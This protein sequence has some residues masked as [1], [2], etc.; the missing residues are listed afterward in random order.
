[1][2]KD[3][4]YRQLCRLSTLRAGWVRVEESDGCAGVDGITIS[5]FAAGLEEELLRLSSELSKET[6]KPLPLLR[7]SVPKAHGGERVLSVPTVRDRVVENGLSSIIGPIF[8]REFEACSFAYRTGHSVKQALQQIEFLHEAGYTW[9]VDADITSYFDNV[10][11]ALLLARVAGLV[12]SARIVN[13]VR[14]A[15][16]ARVYDGHKI[17]LLERGLPQGAPISPLL[18]NLYLDSFDDRMLA[19]G[20][21]L[22]RFADDFVV[23]CKSE[24]KAQHALKLTRQLL[25][26]LH[27]TLNEEKTRIT[28]FAGGFDYL[29][30]TFIGNL[31]FVSRRFRAREENHVLMPPPLPVLRAIPMRREPFSPV[32]RDA[33][34]QA[35][36][37]VAGDEVPSFFQRPRG[38]AADLQTFKPG[39]SPPSS[40]VSKD[41]ST[42]AAAAE[43]QLPE[44]ESAETASVLA[45][46]EGLEGGPSQQ[47]PPDS[48]RLPPP[49]LLTLRTLYIHEH[50]ALIRCEDEHLRV[51]KDDVELLSLPAFKIDQIVLFGNS[52]ITTSA[53]KFCLR[54]GIPI[55]ILSGQ[56]QFFGTVESTGNQ[57]V[58]LQQIQFQRLADENFVL[59]TARQIV[60]GKISNSRT[61][62]QRRHR[63][64]PNDRLAQSIN[65]LLSLAS[66]LR[67]AGT[68]D[69]IRGHEGAAAASYFLAFA[70][71]TPASFKFSK[72]T[73]QPPL[74]PVNA[75]LSFGYTLLFY[76]IYAIVRLRGLS[77]YVGSLHALRQGHPA[78][79]SDLIEELRAPIID[80]L[81][82][83]LI[84]KM[85]FT[86]A[87]FYFGG[88]EETPAGCFLTDQARRTF[89]A[90]F[91]RR[92]NTL[93]LHPL[94]KVRTTWR[95][96]MDLQVTSF[97]RA[98]RGETEMYVPL[99]IR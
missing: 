30:A 53:M 14:D 41:A 28:S 9:V 39:D 89:V 99:E 27:L 77:P 15:V 6:Y 26:S 94:A 48:R 71:C 34:L 91:E 63:E 18:A 40:A 86:P 70:T 43:T 79:C 62:L 47:S 93:V 12:P 76:N 80:S 25:A 95:G 66:A 97:I 24:P 32:M 29:G 90:Q 67:N 36:N 72:R 84:N 59:K 3:H 55:I 17:F 31:A 10:D 61:L 38:R 44:A 50:G 88:S 92:M 58:L 4:L 19:S 46:N 49:T 52:Q 45:V 11:H 37:D 98:L 82:T 68:L 81:V 69:E 96:C 51:F 65:E 56:G 13:L 85:V 21:K 83:T 7:F 57:N 75:M 22:V 8:E 2:R 60:A 35:L 42:E 33:M 5:R 78:L 74:D 23:L 1:M 54:S 20:Q 87:D 64:K 16:A 73:R